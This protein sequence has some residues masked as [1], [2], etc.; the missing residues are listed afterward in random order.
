MI[1]QRANWF[2][3][4]VRTLCCLAVGIS[5]AS[6][7]F[8]P[9]AELRGNFL[10]PPPS[11]RPWVYWFWL[12]GNVTREGITAD[13]ESMHR[14]GIGGAILLDI[15]QDIPSGPVR[16]G[17]SEWRELFR[18][19]VAEAGRL[20]LQITLHNAA[21]WTGSGGPWITPDLAMQKVVWA[22]TN[23]SGPT[24]FHGPLPSMTPTTHSAG[25]IATLAFPT[26]VSDGASGPGFA[27]KVTA[28]LSAGFEPA[29]LLDGNP[30]TFVTLPAP[31][32]HKPQYL[33]LEFS[34]PFPAAYSQT[35]VLPKV[36]AFD[37]I[38]T[39]RIIDLT[40]KIDSKGFLTWDVPPGQWTIL[41]LAHEPVG[42]LNHPAPSEGEGLECDKLSRAAVEAHFAAFLGQ[43]ITNVGTAAGRS[44]T[45]AFIE[46]WEVGFQNW[47]PRF[48]EEFQKRRGYDLLAYLPIFTG[49]FVAG[50]EQSERFLWDVRRTIAD[51]INDNYAGHFAELAHQHGLNL[52]IEAYGNGPLDALG[53]AA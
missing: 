20:G 35:S 47:T 17:S 40:S 37:V 19:T 45:G 21:G 7:A 33:Q 53:Y 36:P 12:N 15:V 32:P 24:R 52:T 42:T 30:A 25:E 50:P 18:H 4:L 34:G 49:R 51:L 39:E 31:T 48:R 28:S 6:S 3:G 5:T 44:F 41:R 1:W 46:S 10:Q 8:E 16:F 13:L 2:H 38:S 22:K 9:A 27:P 11:A 26:L 14:V 43:M 23:V 29:K